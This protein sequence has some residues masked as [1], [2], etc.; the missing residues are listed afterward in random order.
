M[1]IDC[2]LAGRRVRVEIY[3]TTLLDLLRGIDEFSA[4]EQESLATALRMLRGGRIRLISRQSELAETMLLPP[5]RLRA[6]VEE[7]MG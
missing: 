4:S 2:G 6:L 5:L 7:H 1:A 3:Q